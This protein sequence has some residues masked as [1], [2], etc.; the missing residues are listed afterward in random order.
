[1]YIFIE[2]TENIEK[3][4]KKTEKELKPLCQYRWSLEGKTIDKKNIFIFY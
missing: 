2:T 4:C 1:M 3:H